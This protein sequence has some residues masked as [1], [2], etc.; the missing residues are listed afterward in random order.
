M[1]ESKNDRVAPMFLLL[2]IVGCVLPSVF[3]LRFVMAEGVNVSSF[4]GQLF[5][6][7]VSTFFAMDVVVSAVTVWVFVFVEGQRRK[8]KR[9]WVYVACTM[10]VGVSLALPLFLFVRE[11]HHMNDPL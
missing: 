2:A 3:F 8:M 6:N 1:R 5:N 9:L 7:N 10:F 11:R 4:F